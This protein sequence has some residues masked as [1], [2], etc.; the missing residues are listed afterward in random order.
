MQIFSEIFSKYNQLMSLFRTIKQEHQVLHA[1]LVCRSQC[2]LRKMHTQGRFDKYR[3]PFFARNL[4]AF[5]SQKGS[6]FNF[7]DWDLDFLLDFF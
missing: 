2:T 4:N 1:K 3:E 7:C 6:L 5:F